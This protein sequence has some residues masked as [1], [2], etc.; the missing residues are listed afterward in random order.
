MKITKAL[1]YAVP[2]ALL[3]VGVVGGLVLGEGLYLAAF[4]VGA[5]A[6]LAAVFAVVVARMNGR[7]STSPKRIA[8]AAVATV[9]LIIAGLIPLRAE[10]FGGHNLLTA[11]GLE[12][13]LDELRGVATTYDA[14]YIEPDVLRG[15]RGDRAVIYRDG[16]LQPVPGDTTGP[17]PDYQFGLDEIDFGAIPG[18]IDL[19]RQRFPDATDVIRVDVQRHRGGDPVEI[20]VHVERDGPERRGELVADASGNPR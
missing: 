9:L 10:L 17:D 11:E 7:T 20:T 18:L 12:T 16:D 5:A 1:L 15:Q 14:I 19:A 2:P 8:A 4:A 3:V 6:T 13:G